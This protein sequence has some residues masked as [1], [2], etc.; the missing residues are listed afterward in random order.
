MTSF[1]LMAKGVNKW[2]TSCMVGDISSIITCFR[3]PRIFKKVIWQIYLPG[4][5]FIMLR[6]LPWFMILMAGRRPSASTND[7][8][9][10]YGRHGASTKERM[11]PAGR[12]R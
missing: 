12:T 3:C 9:V 7:L 10:A 6:V 2:R 5:L 11:T 4:H 8:A 1:L